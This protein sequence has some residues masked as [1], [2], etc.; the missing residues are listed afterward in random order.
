MADSGRLKPA[1]KVM[2]I[3]KPDEP[4][5]RLFFVCAMANNTTADHILKSREGHYNCRVRSFQIIIERFISKI[6]YFQSI[7]YP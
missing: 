3:Q 7:K 4:Y 6:L 5:I 1:C 2:N